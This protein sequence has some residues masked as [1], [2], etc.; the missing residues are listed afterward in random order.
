MSKTIRVSLGLAVLASL[1]LLIVASAQPQEL[2]NIAF[3]TSGSSAA[4]PFFLEGVKELHSFQGHPA[5]A[6]SVAF[7]PDGKRLATGGG[8]WNRG[9]LVKLWE[10][11]S[12]RQVGRWQHTGE[13]L[14]VAFS[15]DGLWIAA[16]VGC[17]PRRPVAIRSA[18][19][20]VTCGAAIEVPS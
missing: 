17:G 4:Q 3:P 9:G 5:E 10:L 18:T 12:G 15:R 7:A 2:G 13:V 14:A 1:A 11:G 6:W 8:D 16:G 20:P 19:M